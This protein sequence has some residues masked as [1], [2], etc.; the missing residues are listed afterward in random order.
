MQAIRC[1]FIQTRRALETTGFHECPLQFSSQRLYIHHAGFGELK[2][3][4]HLITY[5][6]NSLATLLNTL[7]MRF[8]LLSHQI[9]CK[10]V[11][12]VG[13]LKLTVSNV[14]FN[15]FHRTNKALYWIVIFSLL[16]I[17][18]VAEK[19]SGSIPATKY[20]LHGFDSRN[21]MLYSLAATK[22]C[23]L[24]IDSRI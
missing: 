16:F 13:I 18:I 15:Q 17:T 1:Q 10:Y 24:W 21:E 14:L 12:Q 22:C 3:H 2:C 5:G 20:P 8:G 6:P 11:I 19:F 23:I 9:S 4:Q 7:H